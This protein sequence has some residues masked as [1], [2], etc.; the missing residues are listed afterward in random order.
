MSS[1]S[2]SP[3]KRCPSCGSRV[4]E[5]AQV[6]DIC[7][8][9][10]GT[11]Q[12][13][14]R[15]SLKETLEEAQQP[16]TPP[17]S[18]FI[19]ERETAPSRRQ[20]SPLAGLPWG[21]IGVVAVI[22][23]IAGGALLL[24]QQR[25]FTRVSVTPTIEVVLNDPAGL[26]GAVIT[27]TDPFPPTETATLAPPTSTPAPT[28]TPLP[29]T[30][31]TVK[32]GDTCGGIAQSYGVALEALTALNQ[33]DSVNCLIRVGDKLIIPVATP[34]P[35]PAETLAPGVTASLAPADAAGPTSTPP[36]QIVYVVKGG[37]NCGEIA[38]KFNITVD[39][40]IQQNNLDTNCFIQINQVLTITFATATPVLT[41]T[42]FVLQTPTPRVG[43]GA[44]I[45]ASPQDSAQISQ[46]QETVTLQ[47]LTV[48]LL[49]PDEWYV[50]QVQP[51]SAITVPLF[52]TK[53][54]SLKL[55]Q[56]ILGDQN[57]RAITWWVQVRRAVGPDPN[58]GAPLYTELSPP[59]AVRRFVWRKPLSTATPAPSP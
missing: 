8:H 2:R 46:T 13:I 50:V 33:L 22:V 48:G 18:P 47:W 23:F 20:P 26:A 28:P 52:Q 15:A 54:T 4:A 6:C 5:D 7:G 3:Y 42:P 11:T 41:P 39:F 24:L 27:E 49:K 45:V 32:A 31:Y 35:G 25:G 10:F 34:T 16:E 51:S 53:A 37:D 40:L 55:T 44:P 1:R 9:E 12:A 59:S 14:P 19:T 43:Y 21:V 30:E 29:P 58:T 36:S 56:D 38:Q 57:E 17:S